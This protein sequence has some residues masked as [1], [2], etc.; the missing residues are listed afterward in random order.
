MAPPMPM[1][2]LHSGHGS[3]G[4]LASVSS[5]V[6]SAASGHH[7]GMLNR[8]GKQTVNRWRATV[9]CGLPVRFDLR[10]RRSRSKRLRPGYETF[11][12]RA[13]KELEA[14]RKDREP[15]PIFGADIGNGNQC[16]IG[17]RKI[18][19]LTEVRRCVT[20]PGC[21]GLEMTPCR[22]QLIG[23]PAD[24]DDPQRTLDEGQQR[25]DELGG[26]AV[27]APAPPRA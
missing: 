4:R 22:S 21:M 26:R 23:R 12:R 15:K 19:E 2:R 18:A 10:L 8:R 5:A 7:E 13:T 20:V 16:Q 6:R 25:R 11:G 17:M 14:R 3:D 24:H 27:P 1:H 9:S